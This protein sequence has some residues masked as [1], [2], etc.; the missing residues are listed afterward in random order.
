MGVTYA[1]FLLQGGRQT[2]ASSF[3]NFHLQLRS[4]RLLLWTCVSSEGHPL[5]CKERKSNLIYFAQNEKC[6]CRWEE[7]KEN[8]MTTQWDSKLCPRHTHTEDKPEEA[9][10]VACQTLQVSQETVLC[11]YSALSSKVKMS[12]GHCPLLIFMS[13]WILDCTVWAHGLGEHGISS[14]L[15]R[16]LTSQCLRNHCSH[17]RCPS[18]AHRDVLSPAAFCCSRMPYSG[19]GSTAGWCKAACVRE[20]E[21]LNPTVKCR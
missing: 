11:N 5:H 10:V 4:M 21:L 7:T 15:T 17:I 14:F 1:K 6:V 3:R 16:D 12:L 8:R 13:I 9:D 19:S 2:T 18:L 20:D